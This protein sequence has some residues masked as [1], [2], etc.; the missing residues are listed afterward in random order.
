MF[1]Q[2][3]QFYFRISEPRSLVLTVQPHPKA[4]TWMA[5]HLHTISSYET[6]RQV[7]MSDLL[8]CLFSAT[9]LHVVLCTTTLDPCMSRNL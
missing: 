3:I 6:C 7:S 9:L 5:F 2:Q 1:P 4:Q 8:I